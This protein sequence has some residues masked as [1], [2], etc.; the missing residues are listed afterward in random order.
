MN[1]KIRFE[2]GKNGTLVCVRMDRR[3]APGICKRIC[4]HSYKGHN[5][6]HTVYVAF[7]YNMIVSRKYLK[8]GKFNLRPP[9]TRIHPLADLCNKILFLL[10][11]RYFCDEQLFMHQKLIL[12]LSITLKTS[13]II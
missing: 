11:S 6:L 5:P 2:L 1:I 8:E 9:P 3:C 4:T 12:P 7:Q 13:T 10:A